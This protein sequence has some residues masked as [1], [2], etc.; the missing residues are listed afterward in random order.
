MS[1]ARVFCAKLV[2][3]MLILKCR[4][5]GGAS[6]PHSLIPLPFH[7]PVTDSSQLVCRYSLQDALPPARSEVY[8]GKLGGRLVFL[9]GRGKPCSR[10]LHAVG[11]D[12][13]A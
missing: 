4:S 7:M 10:Y 8:I 3:S 6:V 9:P 1:Q 5:G 12:S 2:T 11:R 13:A